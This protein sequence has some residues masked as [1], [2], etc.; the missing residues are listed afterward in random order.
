MFFIESQCVSLGFV[1]D[2]LWPVDLTGSDRA[3]TAGE[4]TTPG[5][6]Q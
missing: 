6:V 4:A 1:Y 3:A 5:G 2:V